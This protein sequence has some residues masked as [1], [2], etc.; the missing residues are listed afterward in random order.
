MFFVPI[1]CAR[2]T[3]S[4]NKFPVV[5]TVRIIMAVFYF[6]CSLF[7]NNSHSEYSKSVCEGT[8]V[9]GDPEFLMKLRG[10]SE[11]MA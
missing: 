3:C 11:F 10:N 2:L 4:S 8:V 5:G 7:K 6:S 9:G 1:T